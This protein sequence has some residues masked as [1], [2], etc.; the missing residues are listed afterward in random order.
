[1][2]AIRNGMEFNGRVWK[3]PRG[4]IKILELIFGICA[5]ATTSSY[6]SQG[7]VNYACNDTKDITEHTQTYNF[8]YPFDLEDYDVRV[9]PCSL[10]NNELEPLGGSH[11]SSA[12][13]FVAV[14]VL[15]FLYCLGALL[16]YIFL[17]KL[18]RT[19]ENIPLADFILTIM[20]AFFWLV[21]S[22]AWAHGVTGVKAATDPNYVVSRLADR[23]SD[24]VGCTSCQPGSYPNY[25][26][27]NISVI[28][29]FLNFFIWAGNVWFLYKETPWYKASHPT[30]TV[31]SSSL[32]AGTSGFASGMPPKL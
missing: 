10:T 22:S 14:G 24:K 23:G 25:A 4:F 9:H 19:R 17:D 15:T 1:M 5:F 8:S 27:L 12:Q 3:E 28:F 7:S 20:F 6:S 16:L 29:G 32:G 26:N 31:A 2:D 30:E 21:A 13:F 18:Y 11:R